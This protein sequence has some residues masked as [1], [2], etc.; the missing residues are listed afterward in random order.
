MSVRGRGH[1]GRTILA[2]VAAALAVGCGPGPRPPADPAYAELVEPR[3]ERPASDFERA[4]LGALPDLAPEEPATVGGRRVVAGRRYLA[5]SGRT[6]RELSVDAPAGD[7]QRLACIIDGAW[8]FVPAVLAP[9]SPE[10]PASGEGTPP[11][12]SRTAGGPP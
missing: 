8:A 10:A 2:L 6:C 9:D 4:L 11:G 1:G 3:T 7:R 5:A 12:E